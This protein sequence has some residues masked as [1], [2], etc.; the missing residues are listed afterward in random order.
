MTTEE[1][2]PVAGLAVSVGAGELGL[3]ERLPLPVIIVDR[4]G[5]IL[6]ANASAHAAC[7]PN[8]E[9]VGLRGG[10]ALRCLRAL[11]DPRGCGFGPACETCTLRLQ[12]ME[13]LEQGLEL[14]R[15][16]HEL[17]VD[18]AG[19]PATIQLLVSSVPAGRREALIVIE[20]VTEQVGLRGQYRALFEHLTSGFALHEMIWDGDG[21]PLDYRFLAVNPAFERQTGL[22][23]EAILGRR[24]R[25]VIPGIEASWI[26]IY[27]RVA[28]TGE[29]ARFES[30]SGP[31]GRWYE[32]CAYRPAPDR[33]ATL[34]TDVTEI[35][36]S[37]ARLRALFDSATDGI[38]MKDAR[39]R[40]THANGAVA[41][42]FQRPVESILGRSD[43]ELLE[44]ELAL[45]TRALDRE[46]LAGATSRAKLTFRIGEVARLL[47][48]IAV[49]VRDPGGEVGGLCGV[50]RD[51]TAERALQLEHS[52]LQQQLHQAQKLEALGAL[53]A[54]VAHDLNNLLTP[55][56]GNAS[57]LPETRGSER[58]LLAG[59]IREAAELA[60]DLVG[61]LLAFGRRQ[62]LEV[63][64]VDLGQ[65]IG[66]FRTLL[67]RTLREDI[68]LELALPDGPAP[69]LAD[70]GQLE[71][72]LLN[73]AVN[74]QD[75]MPHGGTL[76]IRVSERAVDAASAEGLALIPGPHLVLEVVDTGEGMD[77]AT[78][79]RI[80]EPFFTTKEKGKGT[81]LGLATV[82]GIARQHG[83]DVEVES[84]PGR[85]ARFLL[86]FPRASE[87][88]RPA[89]TIEPSASGETSGRG[90]ILVVEDD[91]GVRRIV[92]RALRRRGYELLV[93]ASGR[94]ALELCAR[95]DRVP[96]LLLTDVV[97]P[98]LSGRELLERLQARGLQ[99]RVLFMTGHA[100][101]AIAGRLE[102]GG[103]L[104]RKPFT[105]Q[106]L[107]ARVRRLLGS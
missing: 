53:A 11:D 19:L 66:G 27:G 6:R 75:A 41:S 21:R 64:L 25:E 58:T 73:L 81:G 74:A 91:A 99:P 45:R 70:V 76:S 5:R 52:A 102:Q 29:P 7:G 84:A 31:L 37:E 39:G 79:E 12:V 56:L 67:R 101:E 35:R 24:V 46:V 30:H 18:R 40:Y 59:E 104:L 17:V 82:W 96:D 23:A 13:T 95:A 26:E 43:D 92:E 4:D 42:L 105:A 97:M 57:L 72:V 49:P 71:Q 3:L 28:R 89:P 86:L 98:G 50:A 90:T 60:R 85:G 68:A 55:I 61:Q 51:I 93:A 63:R 2:A 69:L 10:E 54:G 8:R 107:V 77:D 36:A 88:P 16:P 83:G 106:D 9:L 103:E 15:R 44:P 20:D 48:V 1:S 94:E 38:F 34:F 47:E 87:A 78:R 80:F 14:A 62:P 33:F 32:V 100:E 65:V 22:R